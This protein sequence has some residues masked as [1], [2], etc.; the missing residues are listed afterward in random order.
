MIINH[1]YLPQPSTLS[2]SPSHFSFQLSAFQRF[3]VSAFR[4][5]RPQPSTLNFSAVAIVCCCKE[6]PRPPFGIASRHESV[7]SEDRHAHAR[8]HITS[9]GPFQRAGVVV[10]MC[11]VHWHHSTLPHVFRPPGVA[12][13]PPCISVH[14][15]TVDLPHRAKIIPQIP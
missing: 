5:S 7:K 10:G 13:S 11:R 6:L 14:Q 4:W 15:R 3:R 1:N 12:K 9:A 8:Q 2:L